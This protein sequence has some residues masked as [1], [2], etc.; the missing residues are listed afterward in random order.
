MKKPLANT[1]KNS[2]IELKNEIEYPEILAFIENNFQKQIKEAINQM[3]KSERASKLNKI[4]K[5]ISNLEI[6]K[7]WSEESVLNTL[8]KVK[9]KLIREQILNEG[10]RA[11]GRSLN[12]VRPISIETNIL[13]N[14]HG[15]CLF[16]RGQ[17]QALVVATLGGE[18]DAQMIDLL[19]EKKSYKRTLYGKL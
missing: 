8:A 17:T 13:P 7:D 19:T 16:T 4:A 11:D 14:A 3:A 1:K 15:S 9:R 5:E 10:K 6:A 2:Q 12:E 18:N